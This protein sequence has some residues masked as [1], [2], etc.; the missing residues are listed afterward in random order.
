MPLIRRALGLGLI[1]AAIHA[2]RP[3]GVAA[4][5]GEDFAAS[6]TRIW[7]AHECTQ[8]R[9]GVAA[10]AMTLSSSDAGGV[11]TLS[12]GADRITTFVLGN[13]AGQ[14]FACGFAIGLAP[15]TI[16]MPWKKRRTS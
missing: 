5:T 7:T 4:Q 12:S 8:K 2:A 10:G 11:V 13:A 6:A 9:H 1:L 15:Q 14:R 16:D 3:S